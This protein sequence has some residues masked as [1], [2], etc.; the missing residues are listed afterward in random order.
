MRR[1]LLQVPNNVTCL[2]NMAHLF[3]REQSFETIGNKDKGKTLQVWL[4]ILL[5]F[6]WFPEQNISSGSTIFTKLARFVATRTM[7]SGFWS[8]LVLV[9][10]CCRHVRA[11][12]YVRGKL[13][14]E[15]SLSSLPSFFLDVFSSLHTSPFYSVA[16]CKVTY[17]GGEYAGVKNTT[18]NNVT[19]Q[20]W[21]SK[22]PVD[23]PMEKPDMPDYNPWADAVNYCRN[24]NKKDSLGPW[25]YQISEKRWGDCGVPYCREYCQRNKLNTCL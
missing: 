22:S 9:V 18:V 6:V 21:S 8:T 1:Q 17:F 16:E 4:N 15:Q 10:L 19:C 5:L 12:I 20:L 23:H 13:G 24:P 3:I 11:N 7:A 2:Y 25:C 14:K